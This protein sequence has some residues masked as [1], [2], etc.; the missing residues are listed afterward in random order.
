MFARL[1]AGEA[2]PDDEAVLASFLGTPDP[3]ARLQKMISDI[4]ENISALLGFDLSKI[5][6][7]Q[8]DLSELD[9]DGEQK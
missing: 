3:F 7:S 9:G 6:L 1:E 5:D 8:L 2:T 4:T